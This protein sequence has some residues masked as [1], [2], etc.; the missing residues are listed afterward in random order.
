VACRYSYTP[1]EGLDGG[2]R[3]LEVVVAGEDGKSER[4]LCSWRKLRTSSCMHEATVDVF[5]GFA[6]WKYPLLLPRLAEQDHENETGE[7]EEKE[8]VGGGVETRRRERSKETN[9]GLGKVLLSVVSEEAGIG[10]D[11]IGLD[12]TGT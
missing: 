12:W 11:G 5:D 10:W 6:T 8:E 4:I 9:F 7:E 2:A 1:S 3:R